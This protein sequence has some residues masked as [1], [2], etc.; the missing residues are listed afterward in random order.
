LQA[1]IAATKTLPIVFNIGLNP[2][3]EG[4]VASL[5]RPGGNV[6][7]VNIFAEEVA[8]KR[9]E[10]LRELVPKATM[11]ALL[12]NRGNPASQTERRVVEAAARDVRHG[13]LV[14]EVSSGSDMEGAFATL[15]ERRADT[16]LVTA[17]AFLLN[18]RG[19]IVALAAR[20]A[21]PAVS[22]EREFV[23][24]GGLMSYG[25]PL[26]DTY[27]QAGVSR[28]LCRPNPQRRQARRPVD[29]TGRHD[30]SLSST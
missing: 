16:L 14:L 10:L 2:V 27:H 7:G 26:R 12:V 8:G 25:T 17:D 13:L 23:A 22:F 18:Q 30:S 1:A 28:R 21:I 11:T 29:H 20:H 19:Q 5:N 24:V 6:T 15:L 3:S 4:Y 9:F